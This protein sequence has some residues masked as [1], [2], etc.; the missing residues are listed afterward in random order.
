[1]LSYNLKTLSKIK[2]KLQSSPRRI[3]K[4]KSESVLDMYFNKP[5]IT[6]NFDPI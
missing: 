5:C 1:M 4:N 6:G 2:Q 3:R